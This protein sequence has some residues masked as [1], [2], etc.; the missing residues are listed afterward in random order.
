MV[1]A[2][3]EIMISPVA[4]P[5]IVMFLPIERS[6][7]IHVALK[8]NQIPHAAVYHVSSDPASWASEYTH[9]AIVLSSITYMSLRWIS[10]MRA[11]QSSITP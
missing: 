4:L 8:C 3:L 2:G 7:G 10:V 9:V 1:I 6:T 11:R 5:F